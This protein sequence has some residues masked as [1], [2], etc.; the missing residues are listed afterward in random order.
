MK[1][2]DPISKGC[3]LNGNKTCDLGDV[4]LEMGVSY[5][6]RMNRV[7]RMDLA[8]EDGIGISAMNE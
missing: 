1:L 5:H 7:T 2:F 6:Q 3:R 8:F 4:R